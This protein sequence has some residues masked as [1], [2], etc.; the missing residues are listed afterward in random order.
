LGRQNAL[1]AG[2]DK[3]CD[4]WAVATT[5]IENCRITGIEAHSSLTETLTKLANGHRTNQFGEPLP[6]PAVG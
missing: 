2:C 5:L 1:F 3:S 6:W 4:N